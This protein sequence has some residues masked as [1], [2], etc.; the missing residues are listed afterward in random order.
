M[1][2]DFKTELLFLTIEMYN[3]REISMVIHE[4]SASLKNFFYRPKPM[5]RFDSDL[6]ELAT[7]EYP[8]GSKFLFRMHACPELSEQGIFLRGCDKR[9]DHEKVHITFESMRTTRRAFADY[10]KNLKILKQLI[11]NNHENLKRL[12][13]IDLKLEDM[14]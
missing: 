9:Y 1:K 12:S 5:S 8:D 6:L 4:Q 13:K 3:T 2:Y 10:I 14:T 7:S 11:D